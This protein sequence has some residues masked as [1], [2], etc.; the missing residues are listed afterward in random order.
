M[1]LY[2]TESDIKVYN[3]LIRKDG[4]NGAPTLK[5]KF[6]EIARIHCSLT[7]KSYS[8]Y[9]KDRIF[10]YSISDPNS[11]NYIINRDTRTIDLDLLK[12]ENW[13]D[14]LKKQIEDADKENKIQ[15]LLVLFSKYN[16]IRNKAIEIAKE[17]ALLTGVRFSDVERGTF[18]LMPSITCIEQIKVNVSYELRVFYG[19]LDDYKIFSFPMELLVVDNWKEKLKE[20]HESSKREY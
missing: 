7:D 2:I 12:N 11:F 3:D 1:S 15:D 6:S 4:P 14:I 5:H 9:N 10:F 8:R 20:Y 18:T 19:E 13:Q 16:I 17:Y